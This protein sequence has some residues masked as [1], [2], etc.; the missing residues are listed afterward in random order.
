MKSKRE[1]DERMVQALER[2]SGRKRRDP[3]YPTIS[4][5]PGN[6]V[7]LK[8]YAFGVFDPIDAPWASLVDDVMGMEIVPLLLPQ[9][10]RP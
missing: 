5:R 4:L 9:R 3:Y 6:I 10:H 8:C 7:R 1:T 2:I